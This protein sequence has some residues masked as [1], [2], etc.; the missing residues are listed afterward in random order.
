MR[1]LTTRV[2]KMRRSLCLNEGLL[3]SYGIGLSLKHKPLFWINKQLLTGNFRHSGSVVVLATTDGKI[4]T[5]LHSCAFFFFFTCFSLLVFLF[6]VTDHTRGIFGVILKRKFHVP[7]SYLKCYVLLWTVL[8]TEERKL[9]FLS[10]PIPNK[11]VYFLSSWPI[12]NEK[13]VTS[14]KS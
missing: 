3:L 5:R 14:I 11:V 2:V 4:R 13:R 7:Q 6:C 9:D 1:D 12:C 10:M 8:L